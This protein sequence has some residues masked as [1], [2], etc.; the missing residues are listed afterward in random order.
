MSFK[1]QEIILGFSFTTF[2]EP[3]FIF[4]GEKSGV[5]TEM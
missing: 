2:S 4:L 5:E 3:S 1:Y